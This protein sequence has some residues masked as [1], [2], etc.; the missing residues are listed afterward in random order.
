MATR[1]LGVLLL[2]AMLAPTTQA[3]SRVGTTAAS[4]LTL[5]AGA[6]GTALGHA[7]TAIA[8]GPDGL[9]WNP[10]GAARPYLGQYAGG[11]FFSNH[12]WLADIEYNTAGVVI[13]VTTSGVLGLSLASLDYGRQDVR[14]ELMPQGTGETFGASDL[15]IGLTYAQPLTPSFYFGATAKYVRQRIRDMN[16]STVAFDFGFVLVT[17]YLQH[18]DAEVN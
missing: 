12:Q 7:Y 6:R 5:G 17:D 2:L 11:A 3:Q 18:A 9:F 14:T 15:S 10:G 4:F 13:P 16:A 1:F 8:T